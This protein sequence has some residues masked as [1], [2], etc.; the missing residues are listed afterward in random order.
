MQARPLCGLELEQFLLNADGSI[1][2]DAPPVLKDAEERRPGHFQ[3][4]VGTH[5]MEIVTKPHRDYS[6]VLDDLNESLIE[7]QAVTLKRKKIVY[8]F[9]TYPGAY[10]PRINPNLWYSIKQAIL[11]EDKFAMSGK[12]VGFH[13]HVSLPARSYEP[14]RR[15]LITG[16]DEEADSQTVS[17]Y[18]LLIAADPALTTFMQ[19]SPFIQG[20]YLAKDSRMLFYRGGTNLK[21]DGLYSKFQHFGGLEGYI[22]TINDIVRRIEKRYSLWKSALL[23]H[24]F[25]PALIR[26]YGRKLDYAWNPVKINKVGTLEQR[27]MDANLPSYI[28]ASGVLIHG[29]LDRVYREKLHVNPSVVGIHEPFKVDGNI[30]HV[31]PARVVLERYQYLS[32]VAGLASNEI[33]HYAKSLYKFALPELDNSERKLLR[34]VRRMLTTRKTMSDRLIAD[35]KRR[36]L[37]KLPTLNNKQARILAISWSE[38]LT[39]DIKQVSKW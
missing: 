35:S 24:G 31:P 6:L 28:A 4:E 27:G 10:E 1:C 7:L 23:K 32:A 5:M 33:F 26:R 34:Q 8:P 39:R 30:L 12:C 36:G 21:F 9:A 17:A 13:Q 19:S 37:W 38:M 14:K 25:D 18:N 16:T 2:F 3:K 20:S 29:M 22:L 11:G 15:V